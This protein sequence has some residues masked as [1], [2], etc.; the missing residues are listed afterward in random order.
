[1][2][3]QLED[4]DSLYQEIVL[5]HY[6]SPRNQGLIQDPDMN[7]EGVNPFCGDRVVLTA[8]INADGR[9]KKVGLTGE[10]CAISQSSASMLSEAIKGLDLEEA[11]GLIARFRGM[12]QGDDLSEED[13]ESLGDLVVL[14]G[15]RQYP[16]RIKCA[17]LAWSTL[18]DA[19]ANL[20]S[21]K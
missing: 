3:M 15:V 14:Q 10:G 6:K 5:D 7:A 11:K 18:Q 19:I 17:L 4:L 16:I 21:K 8:G 9:I 20:A 1:M 13:E 12:M 2:R